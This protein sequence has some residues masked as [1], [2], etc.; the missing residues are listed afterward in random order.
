LTITGVVKLQSESPE[1]RKREN[2]LIEHP[3]V[4]VPTQLKEKENNISENFKIVENEMKTNEV[5]KV[6]NEMK[7]Q[8]YKQVLGIKHRQQK[9]NSQ[10]GKHLRHKKLNFNKLRS[11][12]QQPRKHC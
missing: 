1:V 12:L 9:K 5:Y 6:T 2:L 3:S 7:H 11:N 8:S 10:Y 4:F